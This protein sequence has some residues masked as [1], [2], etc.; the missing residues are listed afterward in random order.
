M[1]CSTVGRGLQ[2]PGRAA[3]TATAAVRGQECIT[4]PWWVELDRIKPAVKRE[5]T[6]VGHIDRSDQVKTR[7]VLRSRQPMRFREF[8]RYSPSCTDLNGCHP[9][10]V[11]GYDQGVNE[12]SRGSRPQP[13]PSAWL[14][15]R[16]GRRQGRRRFENSLVKETKKDTTQVALTKCSLLAL[17]SCSVPVSINF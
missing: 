14:R 12:M 11:N 6:R 3:G 5:V 1:A 15:Q 4:F 2:P 16:A 7:S 10:P 8:L 17:F 13:G 9:R